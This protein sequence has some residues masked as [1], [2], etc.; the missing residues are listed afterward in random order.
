MLYKK[1]FSGLAFVIIL[2]IL[3]TILVIFDFIATEK[4]PE[5]ERCQSYIRSGDSIKNIPA[6]C[7]K[8]IELPSSSR[9]VI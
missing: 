5:K 1:G 3:G 6:Y 8:Y 2:A 7:L 9:N 4:L